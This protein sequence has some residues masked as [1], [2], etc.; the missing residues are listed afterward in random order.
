M[1]KEIAPVPTSALPMA[2]LRD[3]LR[4]G[5]GFADDALMD[6]LLEAALR[7]ALAKAEARCG[8]AI[9]AR[10]FEWMLPGWQLPAVLPLANVTGVTAVDVV[11]PDGAA[12]AVDAARWTLIHDESFPELVGTLPAV[13]TGGHVRVRFEA[14]FGAWEDVP[15]EVRLAVLQLSTRFYEDRGADEAGIPPAIAGLL[16]PWRRMRMGGAA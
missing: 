9:L 5:T 12:E 2:A 7:A 13:P 16:A 1:P 11:G 3:Q 4:L 10:V 14:G 6:P 8:R 15:P